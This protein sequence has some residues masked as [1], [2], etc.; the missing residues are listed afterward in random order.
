MPK[1]LLMTATSNCNSVLT[2]IPIPLAGWLG[3]QFFINDTWK[4]DLPFLSF[5]I[6]KIKTPTQLEGL[7]KR[8]DW[9]FQF[10]QLPGTKIWMATPI[11]SYNDHMKQE[12]ARGEVTAKLIAGVSHEI[13]NP[14]AIILGIA[15]MLSMQAQK[16][17]L[18]QADIIKFSD[19]ITMNVDKVSRLVKSLRAFTNWEDANDNGYSQPE[20][21][22]K[23]VFS[24]TEA[25]FK[26]Y[27]VDFSHNIATGLPQISMPK[28]K[29]VFAIYGILSWRFDILKNLP[30]DH[31]KFIKITV[32][33]ENS[34]HMVVSLED[35]GPEE[36]KQNGGHFTIGVIAD[37]LSKFGG[38][39]QW[40]IH[41]NKW[42][43]HIAIPKSKAA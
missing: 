42:S 18:A 1:L 3:E 40:Q 41:T 32:K 6:E 31:A 23:E 38:N 13:N 15:A 26:N 14:L 30:D 43:C 17:Q 16:D 9:G 19:K 24:F 35:S 2:Q 34:S 11:F 27:R 25:R 36:L 33:N 29:A 4:K 20:E 37:L 7:L 8:G 28:N 39:F 21:I 12:A 5:Q 10:D 22:F